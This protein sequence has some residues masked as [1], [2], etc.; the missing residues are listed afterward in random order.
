GNSETAPVSDWLASHR[1]LS[2]SARDAL[3]VLDGLPAVR[4]AFGVACGLDSMVLGEP[5]IL[6]Q[7]KQAFA[8]S[9]DLGK[10]GP[11]L[12]LLFQQAFA[13]AKHVRTNTQIGASPVSI[14]STAV[15]LARQIFA[16]F[17]KNQAL[18]IGAGDTIE[19]TARHLHSKGLGR[20]VIANRSVERARG[21]ALQFGAYAI[22]L[23]EIP[24]HLGEADMVISSTA[25]PEPLITTEMIRAALAQ[26]RRKPIFLVDLAVPR[27]I[28]AEVNELEDVY[29]YTLDE[30]ND[31]I[32]RNQE[33]REVAASEA[34]DMIDVAAEQFERLL[35]SRDT[36]PLVR[37][38]RASVDALREQSLAEARQMIS[39]G[40][41]PDEVLQFLSNRLSARLMHEPTRRIR[42]AGAD[43]DIALAR[44]ARTLFGLDEPDDK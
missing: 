32:V 18:L 36:V 4:H 16:R 22:S 20:M 21:L 2:E 19:L 34:R 40:R 8:A 24:V 35:A 7:T 10:T 25:S 44:A 27:D 38:L 3:Y 11:L 1:G 26:R 33:N 9:Q 37:Q 31:T 41:D 14:A 28:A 15:G 42:E 23:A 12:N 13:V 30:L 39:S 43:T 17:D 6:G 5:Q 29:L